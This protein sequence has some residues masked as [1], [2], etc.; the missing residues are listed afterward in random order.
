MKIDD[1]EKNQRAARMIAFYGYIFVDSIE[2]L[3]KELTEEKLKDVDMVV[4]ELI[5]IINKKLSERKTKM[6]RRR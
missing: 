3:W 2:E 1:V 6:D 5:R 4:N